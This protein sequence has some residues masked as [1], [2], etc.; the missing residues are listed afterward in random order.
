SHPTNIDQYAQRVSERIMTNKANE[1]PLDKRFKIVPR[2][3]WEAKDN[4]VRSFLNVEY[5]GKCQICNYTFY[6][7]DGQPYFEGH[8]LVSSTRAKW[9]DDRGNILC[10][11]ANC[12][13]KSNH[14]SVEMQDIIEQITQ[15][16]TESSPNPELSVEICGEPVNIRFS[17]KHII[18][19][20]KLLTDSFMNDND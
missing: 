15:E 19:L 20:Q 4:E 7:Q 9:L 13:A 12:G 11:C 18:H 6:K 1:L 16:V 3:K 8:Y 17:K 2:K 14:G 10:L 5:S